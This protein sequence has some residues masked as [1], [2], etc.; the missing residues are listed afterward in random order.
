MRKEIKS[1]ASKVSFETSL[2]TMP[3]MERAA[4]RVDDPV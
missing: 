2:A 3:R 4:L 1:S